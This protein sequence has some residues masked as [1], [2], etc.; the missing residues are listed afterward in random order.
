MRVW[1]IALGLLVV[2]Y[3]VLLV[4]TAWRKTKKR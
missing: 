2:A 4:V 3:A 1:M